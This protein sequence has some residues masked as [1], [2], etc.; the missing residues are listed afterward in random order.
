MTINKNYRYFIPAFAVLALVVIAVTLMTDTA[1]ANPSV[2]I[3]TATATATTSPAYLTAGTA[4]TTLT[5]DLGSGNSKAADSAELLMMLAG[6]STAT[7]LNI[8][9]QYSQNGQDWYATSNGWNAD[10]V[11]TSTPNISMVTQYTFPFASS[12]INRSVVTNAN[13]A[14]STRAV[15][16]PTPT[17]YV[18]AVFTLPVGSAG[19]ALYASFTAK[20]QTP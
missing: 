11:S 13:S 20:Q 16:V 15:D 7:T 6:S 17:R 10:L 14:T 2:F 19:A 3:N 9:I 18:R 12:T 1:K 8:D 4:T 5:F